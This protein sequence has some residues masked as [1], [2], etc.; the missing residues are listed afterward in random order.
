MSAAADSGPGDE[1]STSIPA[2]ASASASASAVASTASAS[3]SGSGADSAGSSSTSAYLSIATTSDQSLSFVSTFDTEQSVPIDIVEHLLRKA[4]WVR[5][6]KARAEQAGTAGG[7]DEE[8][9][10]VQVNLVP[11]TMTDRVLPLPAVTT[12]AAD[13]EM[14]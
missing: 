1:T 2:F 5:Y 12:V 3:A 11:P 7:A 6:E 9:G 8:A 13:L 4:M 14:D 10:K